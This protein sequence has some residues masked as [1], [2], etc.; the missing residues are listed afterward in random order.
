MGRATAEATSARTVTMV[1]FMA[2]VVGGWRLLEMIGAWTD[3]KR[4]GMREER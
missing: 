1:S 3:V 4:I 2:V